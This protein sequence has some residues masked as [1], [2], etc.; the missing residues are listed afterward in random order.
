MTQQT[1]YQLPVA[2][3][4][5]AGTFFANLGLECPWVG[6]DAWCD[7]EKNHIRGSLYGLKTHTSAHCPL[8]VAAA[9]VWYAGEVRAWM[10]RHKG[11]YCEVSPE[12]DGQWLVVADHP[13]LVDAGRLVQYHTAQLEASVALILAVWQAMENDDGCVH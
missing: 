12:E 13:Y 7:L 10:H 3:L 2:E 5:Q 9:V 8:A 11:C 6:E 1:N 4:T